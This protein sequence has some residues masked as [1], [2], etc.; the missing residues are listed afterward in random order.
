M[1]DKMGSF[2]DFLELIMTPS[3]PV[4][5]I[6]AAIVLLFPILLHYILIKSTPYTTLPSVLLLGPAGAGKTALLTL[7][8][9]GDAPAAT[10]TSQRPQTVEL[11]ASRDS[12]TA[13]SFR[14]HDDTSGTH[15]KFLLVDTP[16][17]GK[18]RN[19]AMDKLSAAAAVTDKSKLRAILFVVD[20]AA[21]GEND[22][23]APTAGYL[24]DVLL[25]LQKRAA[26]GKSSKP[27]A[28]VPVLV[29]ANKTDLFTA[30][31]ATLVKSSLEA[32]ITR[33]R[34]SRS[35]GLLDSGVGIDDVGSEEHDDW[36]GA[37][38]TEKF[39]FDQLREFDIDVDVI[40][41]NITGSGSG[42]DKWWSWIAQR[43]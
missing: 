10:H 8:E 31:P 19:H 43:V 29:A 33:I 32:E 30:L 18:L 17:H 11:T 36:L 15:T 42:P 4:L 1:A 7:F 21:I 41:G 34:S 16:G 12:K 39:T 23:L 9:R 22:V 20:A 35:K 27:P 3:M 6:G 26:S 28:P 38:G 2:T 24:Y 25:A 13:H 14:N 40:G 37:Y 5:A